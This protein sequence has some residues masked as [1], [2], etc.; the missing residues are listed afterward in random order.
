MHG[1]MLFLFVYKVQSLGMKT[2]F[3]TSKKDGKIQIRRKDS[4][5]TF[6]SLVSPV[7]TEL[8]HANCVITFPTT[9]L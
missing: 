3:V 6:C 9:V 5:E 2:V 4:L 7:M 1:N 8:N